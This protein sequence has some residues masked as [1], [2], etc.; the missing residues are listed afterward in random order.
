MSV[1]VPQPILDH[2]VINV[3]DQLDNAS[4]RF[5][6]LGFQLTERGHHSL[7]SSNHLAIFGEN[8]LELLS[9]ESGKGSQR[10][11]LWQSPLGLSGLVWKCNDAES[12]FQ[13]LQQQDLDGDPPASFHRPVTLP[14]GSVSE[15]HFRTVRLRPS[16]VPNG[17]SFFCQHLTPEAVWQ[18]AWQRHPNG[19]RN[20]SEFV[21]VAQ[22]PALSA[23]VYSRLFGATKVLACPEG[24]FVLRAGAATVRFASAEYAQQRFGAL[25]E[26]YNGS[27]LMVA[28]GFETEDLAQVK[29]AL[30]A[31]KIAFHEQTEAIVVESA[32]GFNLALRFT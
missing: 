16:L 9:Y 5:R 12:E 31:G 22:D 10:A 17:R 6:R 27:A 8:Y 21:I 26:D 29:R 3:A 4:D 7:G 25:P 2:A 32:E 11:D 23:Q 18:P 14:D 13:H 24:A 20:I 19:V 28:L 15:A 1:P 30:V